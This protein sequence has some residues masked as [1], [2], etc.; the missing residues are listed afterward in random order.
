MSL[1]QVDN[2]STGY[3]NLNVIFDISIDVQENTIV[4]LLG[5]NGSGKSTILKAICGILKITGGEI[6]FLEKRISRISSRQRV[7][8]GISLVPEGRYVFPYL[9]VKENLRVG[10]LTKRAKPHFEQNINRVHMLFPR[11]KE[12]WNQPAGTLSG[13]EQQMLA[14][15]RAL[16]S[17]PALLMLDEPSL[18]LAPILV[19]ELF[20]SIKEINRQG[21]TILLCEQNVHKSLQICHSGYVLENGRIALIG[22]SSELLSNSDLKKAYMGL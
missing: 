12:R 18:G 7:N 5:S 17:N 20:E 3:G 6:L 15:G 19:K 2:I 9:S 4:T 22:D 14:I 21:T 1:L 8:M 10:A 13:G 11:L 16:M